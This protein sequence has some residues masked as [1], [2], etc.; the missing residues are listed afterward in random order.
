MK[1]NKVLEFAGRDAVCDALT[2]LLRSGAQQVIDQAVK[3]ELEELLGQ[4]SGRRTDDGNAVVVRNGHL[5]EHGM[6]C[7]GTSCPTPCY[8]GYEYHRS[9]LHKH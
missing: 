3:A 5:P 2:D 8:D 4:Y 9:S 6:L 7:S 1:K